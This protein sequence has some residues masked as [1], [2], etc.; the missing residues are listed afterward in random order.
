MADYEKRARCIMNELKAIKRGSE[1]LAKPRRK[2]TKI[3]GEL[4]ASGI[5][6]QYRIINPWLVVSEVGSLPVRLPMMRGS[7]AMHHHTKKNCR[8]KS[9]IFT[10][11]LCICNRYAEQT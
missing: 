1:S 5:A 4:A 7:T 2:Q 6:M 10:E 3:Y 9:H 8:P 11:P